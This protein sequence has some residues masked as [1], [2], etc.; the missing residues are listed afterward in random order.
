MAVPGTVACGCD[1][2]SRV[3]SAPSGP[4][5]HT[6]ALCGLGVVRSVPRGIVTRPN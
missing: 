6:M 1:G 5:A 4:P 3:V 2:V